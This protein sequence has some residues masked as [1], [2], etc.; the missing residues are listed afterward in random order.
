MCEMNNN[1]HMF[2]DNYDNTDVHFVMLPYFI[3]VRIND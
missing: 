2:D 3:Y 1:I